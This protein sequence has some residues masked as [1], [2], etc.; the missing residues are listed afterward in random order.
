[1]AITKLTKKAKTH[2]QV[3]ALPL[4]LDD[5]E[6]RVLLIT[7]RG[8]RRWTIPKGW[9]MRGFKDHKAAEREA[10]EEAGVVGRVSKELAGTYQYWK[11]GV[12][13][14]HLCEVAVYLL[15]VERQLTDWREKGQRVATWFSVLA[16]T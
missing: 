2:H 14:L 10:L 15:H 4:R 8:S 5:G 13:T 7:S 16:A 1:V 11:K 6:M 9:P 3:G 12:S